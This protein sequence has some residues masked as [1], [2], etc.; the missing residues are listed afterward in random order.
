MK[1]N[2]KTA[3]CYKDIDWKQ[4]VDD[5]S[6]LQYEILRAYRANDMNR[7][8]MIQAQLTRSFSARALAVR[9]VASNSGRNTPG[10]DGIIWNQPEQKFSA[11]NDL[12][13]LSKYKATPVKRRY[14][15]K[16]DGKRRPLVYPL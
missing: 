8:Q 11:I 12:K 4:C 7:V 9:K 13:D 1:T 16:A 10:V 6:Q 14:I 3:K 5:L 15:P 2:N